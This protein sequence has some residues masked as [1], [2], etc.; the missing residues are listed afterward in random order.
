MKNLDFSNNQMNGLLN[1]AS[2]KLGKSPDDIKQ[3]VESG[4]LDSIT[5]NLDPKTAQKINSIIGNPEALEK[6]M[7]NEQ[8]QK[9][10]GSLG[11]K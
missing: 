8:L 1:M 5:A 4:N 3:A 9:L 10:L 6:L 11:K 2:D 7:K